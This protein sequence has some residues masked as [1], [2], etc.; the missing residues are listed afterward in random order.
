ENTK[1]LFRFLAN[2]I[3]GLLIGFNILSKL[4]TYPNF[5]NIRQELVKELIQNHQLSENGLEYGK[6][7][8]VFG[9][10][11]LKANDILFNNL[12]GL[13]DFEDIKNDIKQVIQEYTKNNIFLVLPEKNDTKIVYPNLMVVDACILLYHIFCNRCRISDH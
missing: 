6:L 1:K 13:K 4:T 9:V 2:R 7:G 3:T 12:S 10:F 5:V 8:V 11:F